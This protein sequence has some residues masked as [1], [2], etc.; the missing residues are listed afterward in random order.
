MA[1]SAGLL[2]LLLLLLCC[3]LLKLLVGCPRGHCI[4]VFTL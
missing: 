4:W 1:V 2:L 3:C